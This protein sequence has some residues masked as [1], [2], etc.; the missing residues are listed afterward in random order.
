MMVSDGL[1]SL[2]EAVGREYYEGEASQTV[3]VFGSSRL[4]RGEGVGGDYTF[5]AP[6]AV[7][8][9]WPGCGAARDLRA[10]LE[11]TGGGWQQCG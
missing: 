6:L 4:G 11:R 3:G 7:H 10:E 1:G 8:F 9:L 2:M 5:R